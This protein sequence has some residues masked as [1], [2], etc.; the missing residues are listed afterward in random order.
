MEVLAEEA[1][2]KLEIHSDTIAFGENS[3]IEQGIYSER[4]SKKHRE[5]LDHLIDWT[6]DEFLDF[7][8]KGRNG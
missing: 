1:L 5:K 4:P 2:K 3:T 8:A 6:Y 7:V